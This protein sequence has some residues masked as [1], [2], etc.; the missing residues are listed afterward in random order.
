[1]TVLLLNTQTLTSILETVVLKDFI[2]N[3]IK[4]SLDM[5]DYKNKFV[6]PLSH[7]F[8]CKEFHH[9]RLKLD[10]FKLNKEELWNS[11]ATNQERVAEYIEEASCLLIR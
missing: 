4:I 5:N 6:E 11:L 1:M 10:I 7:L 8:V 2:Q 3:D 9:I